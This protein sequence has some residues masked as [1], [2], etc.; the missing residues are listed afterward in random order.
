VDDSWIEGANTLEELN[1]ALESCRNCLLSQTRK[2][3]IPGRGPVG[4]PIFFVFDTPSPE[5]LPGRSIPTGAEAELFDNIITKGLK[6]NPQDV[7]LTPI[8][9]CPV[10]DPSEYP[11]SFPM[12]AC[13]RFLFRELELVGPK[14]VVTL[15]S[16]PPKILTGM[17]KT[18]FIYLKRQKLI[19]GRANKVPLIVTY[20]LPTIMDS[21]EIKREFWNDLKEVLKLL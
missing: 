8:S 16:R 6:L 4:A 10:P 11:E 9:K 1:L 7:Y 2:A 15:G 17:E 19:I 3:V 18:Q 13:A 21:V 12:K 20:D 5:A 14:V